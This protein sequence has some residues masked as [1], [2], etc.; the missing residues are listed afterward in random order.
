MSES[1]APLLFTVSIEVAKH[2]HPTSAK[3][4]ATSLS[5]SLFSGSLHI[6][7][8]HEM[9][10]FKVDRRQMEEVFV[11]AA[12]R[13]KTNVDSRRNSREFLFELRKQVQPEP[14]QWV[15]ISDAA[16][17]ALRNIDHLIPADS[18]AAQIRLSPTDVD[19]YWTKTMRR[20]K[21]DGE[22]SAS[23]GLWAVR[24]EHLSQVLERWKCAWSGPGKDAELDEAT[25]WSEVVRNLPLRKKPFEKG[26]VYAPEIGSVDWEAVSNAAFVTVPGWPQDEQRKFLQ[27]MYFG[28]YFG[29]ESG[30][31]VNILDP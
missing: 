1:G 16:G 14:R 25:V 12:L 6:F 17:I 8:N 23:L 21:S 19:F 27:A 29:D 7:R 28:T 24:G 4:L 13:E 3:I 22:V 9:S 20:N 2:S 26:E 15:I 30:L 5:R 11:P 31:M 18:K 10:L